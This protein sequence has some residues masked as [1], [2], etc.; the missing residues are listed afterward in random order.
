MTPKHLLSV[1][2][3]AAACAFGTPVDVSKLPP[4][5]ARPVDFAKDIQ[6]LFAKHCVKCHGPEKQKSGWRADVKSAALNGGDN[7][8][9]NIRPGNSADSPLIH[10]VAGL[11]DDMIMPQ[12]GDPMTAEQIGLLRAWIDQGAKW[13]DDSA[14]RDPKASHWAFQPVQRPSVLPEGNAID[15]LIR[16]K[17]AEKGLTLSPEADRRTL[18]RRLSFDLIGLPPTPGEIDAFIAERDPRAYENLVERLLAS[19]RYGERWA[20]HWLDVVRFAES[21]GFEKNRPR[22]RAWPYRD[23]VIRAFNDDKPYGQFIR[24][25]L[26]GDALA[27]DEGTGFLVGGPFDEVKSPDPVL[28]A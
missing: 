22:E 1:L 8:A 25:Q 4:A 26:A 11:D 14:A 12:K 15:T 5:A 17:L 13:P 3:T 10:F 24:E 19:P 23:Y 21:Q 18:I 6:P 9:P 2:L 28:T 7:Y 20:R 27:A 16:A